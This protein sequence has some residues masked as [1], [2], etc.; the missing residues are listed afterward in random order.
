MI[1]H[2]KKVRACRLKRALKS[3]AATQPQK[4]PGHDGTAPGIARDPKTQKATTDITNRTAYG[5]NIGFETAED[6][7]NNKWP[8]EEEGQT[9]QRLE[10]LLT[11]AIEEAKITSWIAYGSNT[12]NA[13]EE[14]KQKA[15]TDTDITDRTTYG[16]NVG[17]KT[18]GDDSNN[19][20][21]AEEESQRNKRLEQLLANACNDYQSWDATRVGR[22]A[23]C[24]TW[25]HSASRLVQLLHRQAWESHTRLDQKMRADFAAQS[26]A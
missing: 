23:G 7:S 12:Q 16:S 5:S 4:R 9:N 25:R 10:Q 17:A 21:P 2:L 1:L 6:D 11:K 22:R 20:W 18:A 26:V 3:H 15:T 19:K 14:K 8:A 13:S 24:R